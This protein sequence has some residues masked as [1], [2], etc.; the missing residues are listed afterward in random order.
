MQIFIVLLNGKLMELEAERTDTVEET[1]SKILAR[2]YN[3]RLFGSQDKFRLVAKVGTSC[4]IMMK[5][6]RKLQAYNIHDGASFNLV[7]LAR[8]TGEMAHSWQP[9]PEDETEHETS[10]S[11]S[12]SPVG[13]GMPWRFLFV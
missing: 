2:I 6:K 4:E 8:C 5:G 1:L 13:V 12:R 10:R 3:T 11:R 9:V 7:Y